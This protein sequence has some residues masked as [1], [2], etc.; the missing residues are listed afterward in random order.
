MN[1]KIQ[2]SKIIRNS[3]RKICVLYINDKTMNYFKANFSIK[4]VYHYY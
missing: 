4:Y 1:I 3:I 2:A